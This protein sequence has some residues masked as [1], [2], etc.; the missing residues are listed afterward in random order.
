MKQLSHVKSDCKYH[1][2]IV[3]KYRKKVLYGRVGKDVREILRDLARQKGIEILGSVNNFFKSN[4]N[5]C[6]RYKRGVH[7]SELI[8]SCSNSSKVFYSME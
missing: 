2:V 4:E 1:V 3:P 8:V 5:E 6:E 7:V